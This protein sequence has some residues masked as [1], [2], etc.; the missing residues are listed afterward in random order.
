MVVVV[1]GG[2]RRIF[3]GMKFWPIKRF[4]GFMRE[5]KI[6]LGCEKTQGL[7]GVMYFSSAQMKNNKK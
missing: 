4:F 6:F 5:A 7:F 1:V 2:V 3:L